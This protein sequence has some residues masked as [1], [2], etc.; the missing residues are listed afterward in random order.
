M[1]DQSTDSQ[2]ED[3]PE[4]AVA[5]GVTGFAWVVLAFSVW[6]TFALIASVIVLTRSFLNSDSLF[7]MAVAWGGLCG[8]FILSLELWR[9]LKRGRRQ[10]WVGVTTIWLLFVGVI[11]WGLFWSSS[12]SAKFE[13]ANR[14]NPSQCNMIIK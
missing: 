5:Q 4:V 8:I 12:V 11:C 3:E 10:A 13:E 6:S 9:Y 2:I 1:S 7:T 14:Y